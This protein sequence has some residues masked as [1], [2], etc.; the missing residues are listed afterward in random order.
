MIFKVS[1]SPADPTAVS[2]VITDP[3]GVAVV[4]TYLGASPADITKSGTGDYKLNIGSTI[5]GLW[6]YA[7][8][9]T[10]LATDVQAGTWTV[11]PASTLNQ[12]YTSVEEVKS[13]LKITDTND[14]FELQGAVQAAANAIQGYTGRHFYQLTET[15][16]F[17]PYSIWE[18]PIDD[19]VSITQL[20]V[21]YNG[22]GVFDTIWTNNVDYELQ[23]GVDE[24]NALASGEK[25][26]FTWVRVINAAGG[27]RF[28]PFVW[29][30]SR[31]DR[32]QIQG[33]WGWPAVPYG[34]RQASL[35]IASEFYKL[36]DSPFGLAGSSEFGLIRL[37]RQNPY[38]T[39]LLTPYIHP[40][41]KVGV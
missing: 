16:T 7:W 12:L 28:F 26:P 14:D 23:I 13:R 38:I 20:A 5:F 4:H 25:R 35:Q 8:I 27:G 37:P 33:T 31:L 39:R 22:T 29:P 34:I 41:R 19:L 40:R 9:G 15:R 32:I 21:D 11:G 18:Q 1:G 6:G 17:R 2:C 30:F 36:K 3:T 24:F 10:G